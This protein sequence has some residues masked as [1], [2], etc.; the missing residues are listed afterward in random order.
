MLHAGLI[1]IIRCKF[2]VLINNNKKER[3]MS[4]QVNTPCMSE[5]YSHP[6]YFS[7]SIKVN[8]SKL[9]KFKIKTARPLLE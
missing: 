6:P 8:K 3:Y 2:H 7:K 5:N 4:S 9:I 1:L